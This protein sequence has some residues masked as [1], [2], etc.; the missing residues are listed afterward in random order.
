MREDS[1][2]R[3]PGSRPEDFLEVVWKNSWKSS[4]RL[5]GSRLEDFLEAAYV[6]LSRIKPNVVQLIELDKRS[7][8]LGEFV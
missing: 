5:P 8:C 1:V 7:N 3:L 2:R 6:P 4:R